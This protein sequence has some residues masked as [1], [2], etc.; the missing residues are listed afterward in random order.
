MK[1]PISWIMKHVKLSR[2]VKVN[3]IVDSLTNLGFEVE[4]V[5]TYGNVSGPLVI[6]QVLKIEPLTEFKKPIRYCTV[7]VGTKKVGIVCGA[8]NFSEKDLVV[9]A[10]PGSILPGD[11]KISE[12]ETYGKKSQGMIC[13]AK[14]LNISDDHSGILVL[15][16]KVKLGTDA[17]KI[18]GLNETVVDISVL[19]DRGYALSVR[20]IARELSTILKAKF[21]DPVNEKIPKVTRSKK[22]KVKISTK[23]A[24]KIALVRVENYQSSSVTPLFIQNR[25]N[26]CGIRTISLPVDL[27]NYF[28]I[29]MGQ[30]LHAFDADKVQGTIEIRAAKNNEKLET[31]DH[32]VRNLDTNDLV[33]ADSKKALSLA[34]VMGGLNSEVVET[35]TN[36]V[37]ESAIFDSE[38]ISSSARKHKLPSEASKRFERGTDYEINEIVAIKTAHYLQKYGNAKIEGLASISKNRIPAKIAFDMNEFTRL[39]GLKMSNKEI[40]QILESLYLFSSI[41]GSKL[42]VKIPSWRHDL[43]NQ[44]DL[45]EEIL[46]VWGYYK[47]KGSLRTSNKSVKKNSAFEFRNL[48]SNKLSSLGMTEIINYPFCSEKDIVFSANKSGVAVKLIN[49]ISENEPFLRTSLFPGL[50]KALERNISRGQ[51][52][53][54]I[55]EAGSVF[56]SN[57]GKPNNRKIKLL[58]KPS[59]TFI[60]DLNK[61]LPRQPLFIN[62]LF[63]GSIKSL[64]SLKN[65]ILIDWR[66]PISLIDEVFKEIGIVSEVENSLHPSFHPGRCASYKVGGDVLG[67]AGQIHPKMSENYGLKG[68]IYGFEIY[69]EILIKHVLTKQAL[70]FSTLPVVKED[71]A[72]IFNKQVKAQKVVDLISNSISDL[73]ESVTLFDA[74]QG[75]NL[76]EGKKSLAFSIRLRSPERTLKTEEVQQ[77]R[78]EIIA[79][80]EKEFGAQLR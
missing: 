55:Y 27:T 53:V 38:T 1:L 3:E 23:N 68:Q 56:Y 7:D 66:Y 41:K 4:S 2:V 39:T 64:G 24:S 9:V 58:Q 45:V 60:Q 79:K 35:T 12:R 76:Q 21:D 57:G 73:I 28:M 78:N 61:S 13:S 33:I 74:Y 8:S 11:F 47:I 34:G 65:D 75:P 67:F 52:N 6:G 77:V 43:A 71:L 49:P 48:L 46:R 40:I 26:Q 20:G 5:S 70:T 25:L 31:L 54:S 69:P 51:E 10:L 29:E 22:T 18:L 14:E 30:P 19:P 16:E 63:S 50:L 72:F 62:G 44:A 17:K 80:V 32:V 42:S 59:S 37:I 15:N 36:L